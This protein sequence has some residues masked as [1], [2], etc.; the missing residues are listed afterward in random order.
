VYTVSLAV[1][2]LGGS[3]ALTRTGYITA[4]QPLTVDFVGSPRSGDAPLTVRFT[5]TVTGTV[6]AYEWRFGDGGVAYTPNPAHTYES[7]GR[8]GVTLMITGPAGIARESK[9]GYVTVN[10]PVGAPSATFS[11]DVTSGTLPLTVTFSAVTSGTIEYWEWEFGD[12]GR[13]FTGSVVSHT[14]TT[15][16]IFDVSLTVSNTYGSFTDGEP[17]YIRVYAPVSADFSGSPTSGMTPLAVSFTNLSTGD[18]DTCTWTFGDGGSSGDCTD[19]DHTYTSAGV[20][21]VSLAVS[22]LGGSDALT[23]TGYITAR[24][25]HKVY[26]PLIARNDSET[27]AIRGR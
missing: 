15:A 23:R 13:A 25:M 7:G 8:F 22:G 19:P 14:Y 6:T 18:Y 4:Y 2:G 3:D 21:T 20:Y 10:A 17:G 26:L 5:S 1:S 27:A 9:A 16:G 24:Q 12:G 11:A